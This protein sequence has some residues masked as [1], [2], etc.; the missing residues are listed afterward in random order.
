[1]TQDGNPDTPNP[2]TTVAADSDT[3]TQPAHQPA[4]FKAPPSQ[5]VAAAAT[6]NESERGWPSEDEN[7]DRTELWQR[8][9]V[10]STVRNQV[11]PEPRKPHKRDP[12]MQSP[13]MGSDTLNLMQRG[14]TH[15]YETLREPEA[16]AAAAARAR[17]C[18]LRVVELTRG[19]ALLQAQQSLAAL[20]P[21]TAE[22]QANFEAGVS[23][24]SG[25]PYVHGGHGC[26][27]PPN[28]H[29]TASD[30][31][32]AATCSHHRGA[33]RHGRSSPERHLA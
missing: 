28:P 27:P 32:V 1:M 12:Q 33:P 18:L 25:E 9:Q 23:S 30:L 26:A 31:Q 17:R 24:S 7:A 20:Q 22:R 21:P 19:E 5:A 2:A 3:A 11:E 15:K 8:T 4:R 6:G 16:R 29:E 13:G 14:T 10:T